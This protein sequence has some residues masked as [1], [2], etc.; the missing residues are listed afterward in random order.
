[1]NAVRAELLQSIEAVVTKIRP[2]VTALTERHTLD[3]D[4]ELDSIERM[5]LAVELEDT[6]QVTLD[7]VDELN[8]RTVGDLIDAIERRTRTL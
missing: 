2:A 5:T 1:M 8:I 7:E 6:W 4:L 3:G